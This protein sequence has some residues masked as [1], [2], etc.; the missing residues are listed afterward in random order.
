MQ[1]RQYA[2]TS[3]IF[4]PDLVLAKMDSYGDISEINDRIS[5]MQDN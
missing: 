2:S 1:K 4:I 5:K 3:L